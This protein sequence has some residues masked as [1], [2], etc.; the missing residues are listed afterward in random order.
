MFL[1]LTFTD[2]LSEHEYICTWPVKRRIKVQ[3]PLLAF[4]IRTQIHRH[5]ETST[6][7]TKLYSATFPW[8]EP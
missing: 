2:I 8:T 4:R 7:S 6:T 5:L 3:I 1:I